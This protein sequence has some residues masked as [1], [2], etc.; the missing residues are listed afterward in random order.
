[1]EV[2]WK[3]PGSP[4]GVEEAWEHH[5]SLHGSTGLPSKSHGSPHGTVME[6]PLKFPYKHCASVLPMEAP[7][8]EAPME[9]PWEHHGSA[10]GRSMEA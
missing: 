3:H 10:H 6:P 4:V 9:A 5:D 7:D 1:M 8:R 2:P